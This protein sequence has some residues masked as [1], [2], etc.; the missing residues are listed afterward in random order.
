MK[1]VCTN[2]SFRLVNEMHDKAQ[3]VKSDLFQL[4][5]WV[6]HQHAQTEKLT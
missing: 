4:A 2:S 3:L 6:S 1:T 5:L